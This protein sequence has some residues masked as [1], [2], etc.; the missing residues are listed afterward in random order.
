VAVESINLYFAWGW[1]LTGM[2]VGA[3]IGLF[4][5]R[6]DWLGGF[7]AWP[8]RMVRLAHIAFLGTGLLNLGFAL[9]LPLIDSGPD[10]DR[11]L[12]IVGVLLIVGAVS[13]PTVCLLAAWRQPMRHLFFIPA[14]SLV[15]AVSLFLL[16][17]L[18]A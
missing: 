5:H 6:R 8:R 4:F 10:A 9:S 7:D 18:I 17:G 16:R 14:G 3:V 1:M 13:M 15:V 11:L 2:I 12:P